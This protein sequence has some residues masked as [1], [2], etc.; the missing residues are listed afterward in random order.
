M[1]AVLSEAE[2]LAPNMPEH[3]MLK[4]AAL[5]ERTSSRATLLDKKPEDGC[6]PNAVL[7]AKGFVVGAEI[8]EKFGDK[9]TLRIMVFAGDE[10]TIVCQVGEDASTSHA[11]ARA[12]LS[13]YKLLKKQTIVTLG[14]LVPL[15]LQS[16]MH[17]ALVES[18]VK[19]QLA[20][21]FSS[22]SYNAE[23]HCDVLWSTAFSC[24]SEGNSQ[25][26]GLNC[27]PSPIP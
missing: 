16:S 14:K 4:A 10:K 18:A 20:T 26:V 9:R 25:M 22:G 5:A 1:V 19:M 23:D 3:P 2:A 11:V 12:D 13:N 24:S 6:I 7:T 15:L 8:E 27:I 21:M 17:K